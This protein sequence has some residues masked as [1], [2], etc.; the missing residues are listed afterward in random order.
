MVASL[1]VCSLFSMFTSQWWQ[2]PSQ[3]TAKGL[4]VSMDQEGQVQGRSH[5]KCKQVLSKNPCLPDW[6]SWEIGSCHC[7]RS[8]SYYGHCA[9]GVSIAYGWYILRM[10][11]LSYQHPFTLWGNYDGKERM[12][13]EE[14]REEEGRQGEERWNIGRRGEEMKK[15]EGEGRKENKEK[16]NGRESS[17]QSWLVTIVNSTLSFNSALQIFVLMDMSF[18][19]MV[20]AGFKCACNV[21]QVSE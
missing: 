10:K 18:A 6:E 17:C 5:S 15:W 7:L 1:F 14:R 12:E 2:S 13:K 8:V 4:R 20:S 19:R 11:V 9:S 3:S 21:S 16:R